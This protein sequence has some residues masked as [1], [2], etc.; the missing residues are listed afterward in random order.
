MAYIL[1]SVPYFHCLVRKEFTQG[2]L[3]GHD[4]YIEA[5][6]VGVLC[7][8]GDS[9]QFQ[10][11]MKEP[12]AGVAFTLPIQALCTKPCPPPAEPKIA[13]PWDVFSCEFGVCELATV[14]RSVVKLLKDGMLAEY[15]FTLAYTGTDVADDPDQRKLLH[16]VLREDGL[17]GA[18][19]NNRCIFIDRALFGDL[20]PKAPLKFTTLSREFRAEGLI[21]SFLPGANAHSNDP[22]IK[23]GGHG[24]GDGRLI[25]LGP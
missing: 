10:V 9:L 11:I 20:D 2:L 16:V 1:S 3:S 21:Q 4:E 25:Q 23:G 7:V 14:R 6:A 19:P 5:M 17:V 15:R 24:N 22:K 18:Y 12:Y 13:E 8:R